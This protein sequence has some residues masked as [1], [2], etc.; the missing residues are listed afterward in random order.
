M[1]ELLKQL[2]WDT[3]MKKI[4]FKKNAPYV[5]G[6]ILEYGDLPHIKWMKKQYS[7]DEIEKV[8]VSARNLTQKSA[9]FWADYFHIPKEKI[10]CLNR[11]LLKKRKIL[12]PY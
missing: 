5:I 11:H 9:N 3:D 1:T 10:R 7:R 12:W 8:L 4:D 6:R 2:F